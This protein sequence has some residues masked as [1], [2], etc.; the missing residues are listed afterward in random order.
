MNDKEKFYAEHETLAYYTLKKYFPALS[1]DEDWQ[2]WAKLH[3]WKACVG[4]NESVGVKFS[5]YAIRAI[6]NGI[7][8]L[9]RKSY[10]QKRD[11]EE[12]VVSYDDPGFPAF[13]I[14]GYPFSYADREGFYN[15]LPVQSRKTIKLLECG[16]TANEV[17]EIEGISS[18]TVYSRIRRAKPI[19]EAYI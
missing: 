13:V 14:Q 2:Q 12:R 11:G 6:R 10:A 17:C 3:L 7:S 15:A 19:A 8:T 4:F 5:S 9:I 18:A 1:A 16:Y